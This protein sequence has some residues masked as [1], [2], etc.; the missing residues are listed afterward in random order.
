MG[1]EGAPESPSKRGDKSSK[2]G[3][4]MKEDASANEVTMGTGVEGM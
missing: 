2:E 1:T 3:Q 4:Y